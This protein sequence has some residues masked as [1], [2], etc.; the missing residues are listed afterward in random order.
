MRGAYLAHSNGSASAAGPSEGRSTSERFDE[1]EVARPIQ[2]RPQR[3]ADDHQHDQCR[4]DERL[5]D[6][7]GRGRVDGG[8]RSSSLARD[9]SPAVDRPPLLPSGPAM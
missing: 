6:R 9:G 5:H 8:N 2:L 7:P 3:D 1:R 4:H